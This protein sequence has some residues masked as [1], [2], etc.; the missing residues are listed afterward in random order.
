MHCLNSELSVPPALCSRDSVFLTIVIS[1]FFG[2]FRKL[3]KGRW[4]SAVYHVY[5]SMP[6]Q[7]MQQE[8]LNQATHS[9]TSVMHGK[10][11]RALDN[12]VQ[13]TSELH[14]PES[15]RH[16]QSQQ[17]T[18]LFW[19]AIDFCSACDDFFTAPYG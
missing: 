1:H 7:C 2:E 19:S 3:R 14:P 18:L 12:F 16:L 6:L 17:K 15:C 5:Q 13:S 4:S 11:T 9:F 10:R 8:G